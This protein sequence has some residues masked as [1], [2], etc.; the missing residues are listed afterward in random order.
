MYHKAWDGSRWLPSATDWEALGGGFNSTPA[1]VSWGANRLDIFGLGS[2]NQ[3]YHKAWDGSRW[4]PCLPATA[5]TCPP[6]ALL[7][8]IRII[9]WNGLSLVADEQVSTGPLRG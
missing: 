6:Q 1:V 4:L 9:D 7:M 5:T 2:D 8:K 3:M